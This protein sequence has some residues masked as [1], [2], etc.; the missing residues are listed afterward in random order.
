[1]RFRYG[2]PLELPINYKN[3]LIGF[4]YSNISDEINRRF[5][6]EEGFAYRGRVSRHFAFSQIDGRFKVDRQ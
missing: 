2:Q 4:I 1:M 5:L 6:H 3:L